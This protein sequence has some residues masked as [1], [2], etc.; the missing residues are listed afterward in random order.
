MTYT[1]RCNKCDHVQDEIRRMDDRNR[2]GVCNKCEGTTSKI[3]NTTYIKPG[4]GGHS[5]S[6]R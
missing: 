6:I 5:G 4:G 1:Y 3:F 2:E